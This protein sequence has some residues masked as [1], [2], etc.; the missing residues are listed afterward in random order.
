DLIINK[1]RVGECY[2]IGGNNEWAN[3]DTVR[4]LC[5]LVDESFAR[6]SQLAQ[7]FPASPCASGA[8]AESLITYVEDRAGHD[9]RY[10]I[11]AGKITGELGYQPQED[12]DSG[13]LKTVQWYLDNE[14]W[15]Q[16]ILDGSYRL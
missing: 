13:M 6:D 4:L 5:K 7:R 11:D 8:P 12:F 16:A 2:N 10:A 9:T 15:W 1:G 14:P 3:V